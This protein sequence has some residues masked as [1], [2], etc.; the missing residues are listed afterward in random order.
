M[1]PVDVAALS[2]DQ[3]DLAVVATQPMPLDLE[4]ATAVAPGTR[5]STR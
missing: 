2:P 5:T 3:P 1:D 4:A